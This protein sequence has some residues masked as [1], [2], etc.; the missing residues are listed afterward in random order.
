MMTNI[1]NIFYVL[2]TLIDLLCTLTYLILK[3]I[4]Y[5]RYFY[6]PTLQ[7]RKQANKWRV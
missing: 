2:S 7:I 1:L 4:L 5:C 3:K 6:F